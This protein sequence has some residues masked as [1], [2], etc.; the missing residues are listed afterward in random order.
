ME[1]A[2]K[3]KKRTDVPKLL[4]MISILAWPSFCFIWSNVF[5]NVNS[6][7]LAFATYD[8]ATETFIYNAGFSNFVKLFSDF[9]TIKN[10]QTM[11]VN[12]AIGMLIGVVTIPIPILVSFMIYKKCPCSGFFAVVLFMPS[13]I[14]SIIWVL[15]YKYMLDYVVPSIFPVNG[16]VSL[17]LSDKAFWY[18]QLYSF[19]LGFAGNLVLYT[20]AMSR[21]PMELIESGRLDGL[22]IFGE[23]IYIVLPLIYPTLSVLFITLPVSFFT[24]SPNTFAFFG[25]EARPETW[26]LGYYFFS[27]L[28][29]SRGTAHKWMYPYA[30]A[31][32]IVFTLIAA[33]LTFLWKRL[34]AKFDPEVQY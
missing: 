10:F 13:I 8:E 27:I 30:S 28:L 5:M 1:G 23:L 25:A 31:S 20:G 33:P 2:V 29:G 18:L 6:F 15:S 14:S 16:V 4:F 11:L 22:N 26:T 32:S 9:A 17:L 24:S 12:S 19:I 3:K 7:T 34:L 21:I